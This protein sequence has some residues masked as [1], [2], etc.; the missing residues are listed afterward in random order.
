M[1]RIENHMVLD[2]DDYT[3]NQPFEAYCCRCHRD[4]SDKDR[5]VVD[6]EYYCE[7]CFDDEFN[8]LDPDETLCECGD[9]ATYIIHDDCLCEDCAKRRCRD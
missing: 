9:K 2:F 3:V 4:I 8:S 7:D 1:S 5:F 6:D